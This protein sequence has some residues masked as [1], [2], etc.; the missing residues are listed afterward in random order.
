MAERFQ[1]IVSA[2]S[3]VNEPDDLYLRTLGERFGDRTPRIIH[4]Y[5]GQKGKFWYGGRIV[6]KLHDVEADVERRYRL[7]VGYIPEVRERFQRDA[8][9]Q[10]EV[11]NP[12]RINGILRNANSSWELRRACLNVYHDWLA[13]FVSYNPLRFIGVAVCPLFEDVAAAVAD[14]E[15]LSKKGLRT[16]L[17]GFVP[18]D[19]RPPLRDTSY[20]R[21]WAATQDLGVP[22]CLH[23][24]G[25]NLRDPFHVHTRKEQ[26]E[27]PGMMIAIDYEIMGT[28]TNDFIFGGILDR[29]PDLKVVC[30]EFEVSWIPSYMFR[31]DQIQQDYAHRMPVPKL[32]M[33][34]SDYMRTRIWHGFIDDP[35]ALDVLPRIG[36]DCVLWGSD[37]PHIRSVGLETQEKVAEL[38]KGVS[39]A[40]Q[41]KIV[42]GN[43]AKVWQLDNP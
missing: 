41:E 37:F 40:D 7:D 39:R 20:D 13:E 18:P 34:A 28:L 1:K 33:R 24:G 25:G 31:I 12:G 29:F 15:R 9:I 27:G 21:F 36:A 10:A 3:H 43:A 35:Y 42:G 5:K 32:K 4:E 2:D 38:L 26:E 22:I 19:G 17:V 30:S 8:G 11:L 6:L 14:L 16:A 23:I